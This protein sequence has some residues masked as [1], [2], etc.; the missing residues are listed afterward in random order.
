MMDSQIESE[1]WGMTS[2]EADALTR[3]MRDWDDLAGDQQHDYEDP[4]ISSQTVET[5]SMIS[6]S[7]AD[8]DSDEYSVVDLSDT[9]STCKAV[10]RPS[11]ESPVPFAQ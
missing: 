6:N 4:I 1:G 11:E 7:D 5:G 8:I 10:D 9:E 2:K 3:A